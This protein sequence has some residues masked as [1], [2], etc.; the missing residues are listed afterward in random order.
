MNTV[1]LQCF[2]GIRFKVK[3]RLVV[4]RQSIFILYLPHVIP[5]RSLDSEQILFDC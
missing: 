4:G 3:R 2:H 5:N 1:P